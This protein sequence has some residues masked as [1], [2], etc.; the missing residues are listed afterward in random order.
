M[1]RITTQVFMFLLSTLQKMLGQYPENS[2]IFF[3]HI[4]RTSSFIQFIYP[5]DL[6]QIE[7][8]R[9]EVIPR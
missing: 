6:S 1:L 7:K 9:K 3:F 4:I 5:M 2:K 8:Q